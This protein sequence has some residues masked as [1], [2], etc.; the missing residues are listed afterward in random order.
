MP[1]AP[2]G[3]TRDRPSEASF[4]STPATAPP[5]IPADTQAAF[6]FVIVGAGT[7]GSVLAARLT[8]Q[9]DVRVHGVEGL[10]VVDAS[11]MPALPAANTNATVLAIAERAAAIIAGYERVT[12]RPSAIYTPVP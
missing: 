5:A 12:D 1:K 4:D 11:V 2:T 10:R 3:S 7:A 9:P 6:D 8:E